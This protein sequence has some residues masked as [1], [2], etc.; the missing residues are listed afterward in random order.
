M[1][2]RDAF[3]LTT[4]PYSRCLLSGRLRR[5]HVG[6]STFGRCVVF[7]HKHEG[8]FIVGQHIR[9]W[10]ERLCWVV[11]VSLFS[12]PYIR[13]LSTGDRKWKDVS[14]PFQHALSCLVSCLSAVCVYQAIFFVSPRRSIMFH[15]ISM[16]PQTTNIWEEKHPHQ[17]E[18]RLDGG[19]IIVRLDS[20]VST[21]LLSSLPLCVINMRAS[22]MDRWRDEGRMDGDGGRGVHV[23]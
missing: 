4:V 11:R 15:P 8:D 7:G 17:D 6:W 20:I 14:V 22:R 19:A 9:S 16:K 13:H 1:I 23:V 3:T 12:S 21:R 5:C 18:N 10:S 2:L